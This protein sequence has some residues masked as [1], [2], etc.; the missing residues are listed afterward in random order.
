MTRDFSSFQNKEL[1]INCV[2]RSLPV[3][4]CLSSITQYLN[5]TSIPQKHLVMFTSLKQLK[6][7]SIACFVIYVLFSVF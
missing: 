2:N 7:V 1:H 3:F 6:M 5:I 4:L